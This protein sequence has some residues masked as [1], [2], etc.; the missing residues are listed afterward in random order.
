MTFPSLLC[1]DVRW[2][3]PLSTRHPPLSGLPRI[4]TR[5]KYYFV[6][7]LWRPK[8]FENTLESF[9]CKT[10]IPGKYVNSVCWCVKLDV[11]PALDFQ[12]LL[13]SDWS[14]LRYHQLATSSYWSGHRSQPLIG[15]S[16]QKSWHWC[17]LKTSFDLPG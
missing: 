17:L 4:L 2:L 10:F 3:L 5:I 13:F 7:S 6:A 8:C 9:C 14:A 15:H 12:H 1:S 16:L 11:M